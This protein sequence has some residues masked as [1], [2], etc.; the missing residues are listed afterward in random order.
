MILLECLSS[1][2]LRFLAFFLP[3]RSTITG[4]GDLFLI[5]TSR[6]L[7]LLVRERPP[8]GVLAH[9]QRWVRWARA[10]ENGN[11]LFTST[12]KEPLV[13]RKRLETPE[14]LVEVDRLLEAQGILLNVLERVFNKCP[15]LGT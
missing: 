1:R 7:N 6:H 14:T 3:F 12:I 11:L 2:H 5:F 9:T 4:K 8:K 13:R 15:V 10:G